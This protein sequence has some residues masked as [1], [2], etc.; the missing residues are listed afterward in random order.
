MSLVD[1]DAHLRSWAS[2]QRQ[3]ISP[4]AHRKGLEALLEIPA[5]L[6]QAVEL[7]IAS[8]G[9][10]GVELPDR[11]DAGCRIR[12]D[13]AKLP[14]L[15]GQKM[16]QNL[17]LRRADLRFADLRG[18][19]WRRCD[20]SRADLRFADLTDADLRGVALIETS[21]N[22]A[23]LRGTSL[24]GTC[25]YGAD[26]RGADLRGANLWLALYDEK[27][28]WPRGFDLGAHQQ[29]IAPT[30]V[31]PFNLSGADLCGVDLR[32]KIQRD[33]NVGQDHRW[34]WFHNAELRGADFRGV[35]LD[36]TEFCGAI[37]CGADFRGAR[38]SDVDL[39]ATDLS[40]AVFGDVEPA[41]LRCQHAFYLAS[42]RPV[43]LQLENDGVPVG[44]G[45]NLCGRDLRTLPLRSAHLHLALFDEKTQWP[46]FIHPEEHRL[47]GPGRDLRWLSW[48]D[49]GKS[50]QYEGISL[51]D[52]D[53]RHTTLYGMDLLK[54]D[55]RRANFQGAD[56]L[57]VY[58]EQSRCIGA[59]FRDADLTAAQL[60]E[61]DFR[62]VD[63]RGAS[64]FGADLRGSRF[65][66]ADLRGADLSVADLSGAI[67][68]G[69]DLRGARCTEKTQWPLDFDEQR[70]GVIR[71]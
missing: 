25:L 47:I 21:L 28:R 57:G 66:G 38:L 2:R 16:A 67:L 18:A 19:G 56:L 55:L 14:G 1:L 9:V 37:L 45:A 50:H 52:A 43:W 53:L 44:P 11:V 39:R 15:R 71:H 54:S 8:G 10:W 46:E 69:A 17:S 12:L 41:G 32:G 30:A 36:N 65:S 7:S 34:R 13:G 49:M 51:C 60:I 58:L 29:R 68:E 35:N 26:L 3:R 20:L 5:T 22:G 42:Q 63:L 64:L 61:T 27:T 33:P 70:H 40:G 24:I 6:R 4:L 31:D 48:S 62:N 59:N 23:V